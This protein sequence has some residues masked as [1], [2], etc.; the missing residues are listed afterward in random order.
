MDRYYVSPCFM[1]TKE[2]NYSHVVPKTP[3]TV[4]DTV[5]ERAGVSFSIPNKERAE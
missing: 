3:V 5:N 1:I 4:R 2:G